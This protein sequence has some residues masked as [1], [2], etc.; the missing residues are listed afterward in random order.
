MS[1]CQSRI[2]GIPA[3]IVRVFYQLANQTNSGTVRKWKGRVQL[4][5]HIES[6]LFRAAAGLLQQNPQCLF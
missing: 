2:A 5:Q 3:V 4:L 6:F 1:N